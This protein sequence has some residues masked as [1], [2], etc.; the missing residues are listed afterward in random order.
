MYGAPIVRGAAVLVHPRRG[1]VR[2]RKV[3]ILTADVGEGHLAAAR[4]LGDQLR[5]A[6]P[7]VEV[8]VVDVLEPLGPI[9]RA[10]LRDGY[11]LQLRRAPWFFGVLF[12]LF[13]RTRPLRALGRAA[14]AA[15]GGR[16]LERALTALRADVVVSTYP[17]ATSV[18]GTLRRRGRV[19]GP[20]C[21]TITDLG[22][23]AFW[24]HPAIDLHLVMHPA[25]VAAVE[26]ETRRP[27]VAVAAPLVG[28][29]FLERRDRR[30]A[31]LALGLPPG[32]RVIVVSGGGWAVGDL[33]GAAREALK[34][35]ET[36]VVC[37]AGRD[38]GAERRLRTAFAGDARVRV[39][40]FTDRM[41]EL[42]R[43]A[44]AIVHTT[45]GVT[46]LEAVASGCPIV[47][48]GA[49]A[50]HGRTLARSMASLGVATR[51]R[52]RRHLSAALRRAAAAPSPDAGAATAAALVLAARPLPAAPGRRR[53]GALAAATAVAA[54]GA[55]WLGGASER[56][57]ALVAHRLDLAPASA[58]QTRL[59]RVGV[60]IEASGRDVPGAARLVGGT[61]GSASF[62]FERLPSDATRRLLA[63]RHDEALPALAPAGVDDW[64]GTADTLFDVRRAFRAR[65]GFI[66]LAPASG[67]SA[68]Q[69]LL[70]RLAG[71]RLVAGIPAARALARPAQ[72][73]PGAILLARV[74]PGPGGRDELA[75]L[76]ALLSRRR[77]RAVALGRLV[78]AA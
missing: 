68:G 75:R 62:A 52:S 18:L 74:S 70:A 57:F 30:E 19:A 33:V 23:A 8:V 59:P 34:L 53:V 37:L 73:R 72:V 48:Y 55:V 78:S 7:R 24:S 49:P 76:L 47:A 21:A 51:A 40:A 25:I 66:V 58:I 61:G 43:A 10:I 22:A 12:A 54:A 38:A 39:L 63:A 9:L 27:N 64:L 2:T 65:G 60:V 5:E 32:G 50:G 69:Y 42:L 4:V 44:D 20:T 14:L 26:R 71:A 3:A 56:A 35:P 67:L 31:R 36:T 6:D 28:R 16:G 11:R 77:L 13:L 46:C 17:A 41:P 1:P 29:A 15:L 45:G